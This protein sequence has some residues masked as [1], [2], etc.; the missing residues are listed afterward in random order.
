MVVKPRVVSL[1]VT[2]STVTLEY[3][4]ALDAGSVPAPASYSVN[5]G[6]DGTRTVTNVTLDGSTVQ[7]EMGA[8][9]RARRSV[10]VSYTAPASNPIRDVGRTPAESFTDMSAQNFTPSQP[11]ALSQATIVG[12]ALTLTFDDA[13]NT[14]SIPAPSS[15]TVTVDGADATV[16]EVAASGSE[17]VVL[18]LATAVKA[19]QT[20]TVAY[21]QPQTGRIES[22]VGIE[23]D[24]FSGHAVANNSP[25]RVPELTGVAIDGAT[26]TLTFDE[27]LDTGSSPASSSFTVTVG[28]GAV[29][30]SGVSI[31]GSSVRLT[32]EAAVQAGQS[33]TV[34]YAK[35]AFDPISDLGGTDAA[36][37]AARTATNRTAARAPRIIGATIDGDTLTL[38]FDE[39]LDPDSTPA[40]GS[41]TVAVAGDGS[42]TVSSVSLAVETVTLSLGAAVQ[43]GQ[44]VSVSYAP[45]VSNPLQDVGGT[46]A[47]VVSGRTVT[48]VTGARAPRL[49]SAAIDGSTLTLTFD[50]ALD[51]GS[52]PSAGSFTV[53]LDGAVVRVGT[54]EVSGF[55]V[56]LSLGAAVQAGQQVS[57]SYAPPVSNPGP[58]CWRHSS[59]RVEQRERHQ[60][61]ASPGAPP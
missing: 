12:A 1:S 27:S 19:G 45:P 37:F 34:A 54:L 44:Q 38:T 31:A 7:L 35:P 52:V 61:H 18:T 51:A 39:P 14:G 26:V 47:A 40:A 5:V 25:A 11:P 6:I 16:S 36:S 59:G 32:L 46:G 41:F 9:V 20:V 50:E 2:S 48:N 43:A 22:V 24:A 13:L 58:R 56:T 33:V 10:L 60:R 4:E 8:A 30:V 15:F 29:A 21:A 17:A 28:S 53:A 49:D 57:V 42:R 23:A 3:S 55:A